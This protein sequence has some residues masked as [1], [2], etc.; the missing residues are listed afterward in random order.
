[1]NGLDLMLA[2]QRARDAAYSRIVAGGFHRF[3]RGSR[4]LL[5]FRVGNADLISIGDGAL[6]GAG[7][8]LLV[9]RRD[10]AAPVIEIGDRVRMNQTSITAVASVVIEEGVGIA[11]GVYIS[12]HSHGFDDPSSFIRD[13]P[14][15]RV[16]P[17]RIGRGA[18]LGQNVVVL[19][20]VTIG[21]GAVIGANSVVREDVPARTVAVGSP[22][23]V[24]RSLVV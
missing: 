6:I 17:V 13:Q 10:H 9:P 1:M 2:L 7:S 24:V 11:R 22:A 4:I 5:P 21:A 3:G 23:R 14:L 15:A 8:W 20:G 16:E 19:P 12:D 18:W